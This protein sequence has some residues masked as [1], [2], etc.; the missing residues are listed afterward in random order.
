[1]LYRTLVPCAE[2]VCNDTT[3]VCT[4]LCVLSKPNERLGVKQTPHI[5]LEV[6]ACLT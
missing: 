1:V 4:N 5:P 6:R 2:V 3:L